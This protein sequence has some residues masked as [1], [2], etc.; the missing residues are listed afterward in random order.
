MVEDVTAA[1]DAG[2]RHALLTL[3]AASNVTGWLPPIEAIIDAAHERGIPVA[4]DAAQLA[5]HR[6][7][8]P[9]AGYLAFSGHKLYAPFGSGALVGRRSTFADGEPFLADGGAVDLVDLDEVVWTAPPDREEAVRRTSWERW[10]CTP[11]S[12][13]S[14][15]SAGR[16]SSSTRRRSAADS[17][18]ASGIYPG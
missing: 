3:T 7:L 9:A 1:L 17:G 8:P 5:P 11:P 18:T 12:T 4:L 14:G 13:S 10:A 16:R 15:P 2:R 6:P